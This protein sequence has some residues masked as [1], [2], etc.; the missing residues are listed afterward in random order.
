MGGRPRKPDEEL[1]RPRGPPRKPKA[2]KPPPPVEPPL[3]E[4]PP[5]QAYAQE[6]EPTHEQIFKLARLFGRRLADLQQEAKRMKREKTRSLI[7]NN[8]FG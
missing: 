7:R 6:E 2:E 4:P 3:Q 1:K 8:L 5:L